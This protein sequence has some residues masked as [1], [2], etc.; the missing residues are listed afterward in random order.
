MS[1]VKVLVSLYVQGLDKTRWFGLNQRRH[2][3]AVVGVIPVPNGE[4]PEGNLVGDVLT[5]T[6]RI[7]RNARRLAA[8]QFR[9]NPTNS[10]GGR[11]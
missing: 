5:V 2:R 10:T 11:W 7:K 1:E 8:E 6:T 3:V 9:K 4:T